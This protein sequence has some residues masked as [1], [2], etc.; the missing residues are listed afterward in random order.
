MSS[1]QIL[2]IHQ[3]RVLSSIRNENVLK[4]AISKGKVY[5]LGGK[6]KWKQERVDKAC[7]ETINKTYA[8]HKGCELNES[9]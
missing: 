2:L 7:D 8:E 9:G 6:Q 5:L 3:K 1:L 4:G